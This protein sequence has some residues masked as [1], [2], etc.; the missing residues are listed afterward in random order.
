MEIAQ[1]SKWAKLH[2]FQ[3]PRLLLAKSLHQKHVSQYR[4][5]QDHLYQTSQWTA[6]TATHKQLSTCKLSASFLIWPRKTYKFQPQVFIFS[7]DME[8]LGGYRMN[9]Y[10]SVHLIKRKD[11]LSSSQVHFHVSDDTH[12]RGKKHTEK[13]ILAVFFVGHPVKLRNSCLITWSLIFWKDL[14]R[15]CDVPHPLPKD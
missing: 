5:Q 15:P 3:P 1:V 2:L 11:K 10:K 12:T 7:W 9:V 8:T 4:L 14:R 13:D 6:Y